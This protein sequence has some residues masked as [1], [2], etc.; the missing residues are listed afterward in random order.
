[1]F[2]IIQNPWRSGGSVNYEKRPKFNF[3]PPQNFLNFFSIPSY[4]F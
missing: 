1:M 4:L 2:G 3:L